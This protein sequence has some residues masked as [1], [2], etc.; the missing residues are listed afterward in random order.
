MR[1]IAE[2]P[3]QFRVSRV[4]PDFLLVTWKGRPSIHV[5]RS[6]EQTME[7]EIILFAGF[8]DGAANTCVVRD[9]FRGQK[10]FYV[11]ARYYEQPS[12]EGRSKVEK[13]LPATTSRL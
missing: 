11:Q 5:F 8:S 6:D 13:V 2:R 12:S 3:E 10:A 7:N 9:P 4:S 1:K